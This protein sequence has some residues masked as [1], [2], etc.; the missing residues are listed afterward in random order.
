MT[1]R[2]RTEHD[3]RRFLEGAVLICGYYGFG[4]LGDEA[5]LAAL[6]QELPDL[7]PGAR[8]VV[9]SGDPS[10]TRE[11][12]G[13]EALSRDDLPG[14]AA[15]VRRA[16]LLVLGGGGLLQEHWVVPLD[17]CLAPGGGGLP[18]YFAYP[19][20]ATAL[21]C[22]I[23]LFALGVGP[24]TTEDGR[25]MVR[26]AFELA[27]TSSVRD[28]ESL[29]LVQRIGLEDGRL[30]HLAADPAVLLEPADD[31]EVRATLQTLQIAPGE[32]LAVVALRHWE[33]AG[34]PFIWEDAVAEA[35]SLYQRESAATILFLP[36]QVRPGSALENDLE[37]ALRVRR[38]LEQPDRTRILERPP[39]PRMAA[40]LLSRCEIVVA[41]RYHAALL[42]LV[43]GVPTVGLAYDP[44]VSALFAEA[45]LGGFALPPGEWRTGALAAVMAAAPRLRNDPRLQRVAPALQ[46]R[47][48]LGLQS[49]AEAWA[50]SAPHGGAVRAL[51][52]LVVAKS[53]LD[54]E[55]G[56]EVEAPA[57][58][59]SPK[60]PSAALP[61]LSVPE[62][63]DAAT[64]TAETPTAG[65]ESSSKTECLA[66]VV[67]IV[68]KDAE[69]DLLSRFLTRL[70]AGGAA[71]LLAVD[72]TLDG[73]A[74]SDARPSRTAL[75]SLIAERDLVA[76]IPHPHERICLLTAAAPPSLFE[77]VA[78]LD[79]GGWSILF[80]DEPPGAERSA[81][82]L[83]VYLRT[84]ADL[85]L[86][87]GEPAPG[88]GAPAPG[89][90]ELTASTAE[91][92]AEGV[93]TWL[94]HRRESEARKPRWHTGVGS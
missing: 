76:S 67:G 71:A 64:R 21:G 48:R 34:D 66:F 68:T 25:R 88:G 40:G 57:Q 54:L 49:L 90:R 46:A 45:D 23:A 80:W 6:L 89:G 29:A 50:K 16:R 19:V 7:L 85:L 38:Q 31:S 32:P 41:M 63:L 3:E 60:P 65:H 69:A 43:A 24:L 2:I 62:A 91:A 73:S 18:F 56:S 74:A 94:L 8:P 82:P 87:L 79:A 93:C 51:A 20:L 44:K 42:A 86:R 81:T 72:G 53:G 28:P 92:L 55:D 33:V 75:A 14:V 77:L 17:H 9:L 52:R 47:A 10:S 37:A 26:A 5:I 59:P 39:S 35:L 70:L 15:A 27:T 61:L 58:P 12:Y 30:P 84:R 4:N 1:D 83:S 13:V 78:T 22:P 11:A 36:A